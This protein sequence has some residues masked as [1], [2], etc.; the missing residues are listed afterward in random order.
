[1]DV[2]LVIGNL[3]TLFVINRFKPKAVPDVLVTALAI[4][5]L[6]TGVLPVPIAV[7]AYLTDWDFSKDATLCDIF[8]WISFATNGGSMFVLTLMA[9][10]RYLAICLP[11]FYKSKVTV[12]RTVLC[13]IGGLVAASVFAIIPVLGSGHM[14]PYGTHNAYCHFDYSGN[15][16]MSTAYSIT[17][18]FIGY[19]FM[20]IVLFSYVSVICTLRKFISRRKLM[21][22]RLSEISEELPELTRSPGFHGNHGSPGSQERCLKL[23][24]MFT[25]MS[26]V[27][28][29]AYWITWTPLLGVITAAQVGQEISP[30]VDFI[31]V[32]LAVL[33]SAVNPFIIVCLYE[34]YR[35]GYWYIIRKLCSPFRKEKK[36]HT[37]PSNPWN[38]RR[39]SSAGLTGSRSTPTTPTLHHNNLGTPRRC[40]SMGDVSSRRQH[41]EE[42]V[43]GQPP[44]LVRSVSSKSILANRSR[45]SNAIRKSYSVRWN[46]RVTV[47]GEHPGVVSVDALKQEHRS[48]YAP[49]ARLEKY[50]PDTGDWS[51]SDSCSSC[52]DSY[53]SDESYSD[54]SDDYCESCDEIFDDRY[55][56][57]YERPRSPER[58]RRAR[59]F[60]NMS[61]YRDDARYGHHINPVSNGYVEESRSFERNEQ[62]RR[63]RRYSDRAP[64]RRSEP[65]RQDGGPSKREETIKSYQRKERSKS[66]ENIP[67]KIETCLYNHSGYR[68]CFTCRAMYG[69][70]YSGCNHTGDKA[71][72][73]ARRSRAPPTTMESDL[74]ERPR[75]EEVIV[76]DFD[77]DNPQMYNLIFQHVLSAEKQKRH[78]GKAVIR[79][80]RQQSAPKHEP[81]QDKMSSARQTTDPSVRDKKRVTERSRSDEEI[82]VDE[83]FMEYPRSKK[84]SRSHNEQRRVRNKKIGSDTN[85]RHHRPDRSTNQ[86]GVVN[87]AY[88]DD[89]EP[90]GID[91]GP[92]IIRHTKSKSLPA[93][94]SNGRQQT[95]AATPHLWPSV[96]IYDQNSVRRLRIQSDHDDNTAASNSVTDTNVKPERRTE[97]S[98]HDRDMISEGN[99]ERSSGHAIIKETQDLP[100]RTVLQEQGTQTTPSREAPTHDSGASD[101]TQD[102]YPSSGNASESEIPYNQYVRRISQSDRGSD[103]SSEPDKGLKLEKP[104][105]LGNHLAHMRSST[106]SGI[107]SSTECSDVAVSHKKSTSLPAKSKYSYETNG[108]N[109]NINSGYV[110]GSDSDAVSTVIAS[111]A[112]RASGSP[113]KQT[114][115]RRSSKTPESKKEDVVCTKC[116]CHVNENKSGKRESGCH[117][118]NKKAVSD[119]A[120]DVR[121]GSDETSPELFMERDDGVTEIDEYGMTKPNENSEHPVQSPLVVYRSEVKIKLKSKT[122]EKNHIQ[123]HLQQKSTSTS[124]QNSKQNGKGKLI[125]D[126]EGAVPQGPSGERPSLFCFEN[127]V[128]DDE[129]F[130][131]GNERYESDFKLLKRYS[132][133]VKNRRRKPRTSSGRSNDDSEIVSINNQNPVH[134]FQISTGISQV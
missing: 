52:S 19:L 15:S 127:E 93:D 16:A 90:V 88:V 20:F 80:L 134:H 69:R 4:S 128:E 125:S 47:A 79:D 57:G 33:N 106:S 84:E 75:E 116:G 96:I 102:I 31:A 2:V 110:A 83:Y 53:Y 24:A 112:P 105:A 101:V 41:R 51:D 61:S 97:M 35:K 50:V 73:T 30:V 121:Y 100:S 85:S 6:L 22:R 56:H 44:P 64:N 74:R 66:A 14:K 58:P 55:A 109:G 71:G 124:G 108:N 94:D 40:L 87:R 29:M 122:M 3:L 111:E 59:S 45:P 60:E 76:R 43:R 120:Y 46:E 32:R 23:E 9:L 63:A 104:S 115:K 39:L 133:K 118:N 12:R 21:S 68:P 38:E 67:V 86:R 123:S 132:P 131:S 48:R 130:A 26:W 70:M 107:G 37:P 72:A 98:T 5:D 113:R 89:P 114:K 13:C 1:M 11:F 65:P 82:L 49:R 78:S 77:D 36:D 28:L 117:E 10:D 8:G 17:A 34:P 129:V 91:S 54:C 81:S 27:L 92:L 99:T 25:R 126:F 119:D 95:E 62:E 7:Y 42:T 103:N 18:L